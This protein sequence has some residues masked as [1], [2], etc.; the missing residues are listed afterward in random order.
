MSQNVFLGS[1]SAVFEH[2]HV[3][4]ATTVGV[5][6]ILNTVAVVE[7]D[8]TIGDFAHIAPGAIV[9]GSAESAG[10]PSWWRGPLSCPTSR[11]AM[12]VWWDRE[13]W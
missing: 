6:V 13:L 12:I 8:Y 9:L 11:W 10:S 3:G 1:G 5:G 7:H 4:P 2:A